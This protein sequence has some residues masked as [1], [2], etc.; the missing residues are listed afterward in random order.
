MD[1][2]IEFRN[3]SISSRQHDLR[4][5]MV[6]LSAAVGKSH[7]GLAKLQSLS[8]SEMRSLLGRYFDR[9]VDLRDFQRRL[10]TQRTELE[11]NWPSPHHHHRHHLQLYG[12]LIMNN[13]FACLFNFIKSCRRSSDGSIS[14]ISLSVCRF[15]YQSVG[16]FL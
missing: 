3:E 1:A 14:S 8:V 15:A 11:V 5:S 2:A 9:V 16:D 13:T 7:H 10:E 12:F 6:R 4:R